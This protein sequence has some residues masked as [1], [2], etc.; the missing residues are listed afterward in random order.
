VDYDVIEDSAR[1]MTRA[2]VDFQVPSVC[3][4]VRWHIGA[5]N[6]G[7]CFT[8]ENAQGRV[9]YR[10]GNDTLIFNILVWLY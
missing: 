6:V 4:L 3:L 7:G 5:L 2:A 1:M 8:V 9:I 10:L